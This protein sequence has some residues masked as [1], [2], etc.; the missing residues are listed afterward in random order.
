MGDREYEL[1]N[2]NSNMFALFMGILFLLIPLI[3]L[4]ILS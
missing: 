4:I 1:I 3:V 2:H